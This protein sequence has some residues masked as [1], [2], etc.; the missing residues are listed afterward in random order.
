MHVGSDNF[1]IKPTRLK[2]SYL[3]DI[4]C[5]L[6]ARRLL[7]SVGCLDTLPRDEW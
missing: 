1:M 4:R 2:R 7:P 6:T 5:E 3:K